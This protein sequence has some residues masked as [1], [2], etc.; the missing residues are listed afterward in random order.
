ML[1]PKYPFFFPAH[2]NVRG[3]KLRTTISK[4]AEDVSEVSCLFLLQVR[5]KLCTK[6][7]Q[8]DM[9]GPLQLY[10]CPEGL[11]TFAQKVGATG[12][13]LPSITALSFNARSELVDGLLPRPG[14]LLALPTLA[15]LIVDIDRV[16]PG[17]LP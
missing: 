13:S 5:L 16:S 2:S 14:P 15:L 11:S 9:P 3:G 7:S 8:N 6:S 4:D 10:T 1:A 17:P 12:A